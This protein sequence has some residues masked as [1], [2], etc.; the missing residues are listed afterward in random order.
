M[1]QVKYAVIILNYNTI[2]DAINAARSVIDN[3][4][5]DEYVVCIADNDS[6]KTE[7]REKLK[8]VFLP[9][10]VTCQ[11][12]ENGGYAKGNNQAIEFLL[13]TYAPQYT[14]IMNPDVLLL[15]NGTIEG[16]IAGFENEDAVGGQPLVW[17]CYYGDDPTVQQNIRKVPDYK[18][19]RN[20]ML[21]PL[22]LFYKR[23]Y[24]EY[25]YADQMPYKDHIRYYVPSGAFFILRTDVFKEIGFFDDHT[26][27]YYEEHILGYKLQR[28]GL[29]LLLMP[30]FKV[31]HEH[32]K[33][34]GA[35]RFSYNQK[36]SNIGMESA[37]YYA[38]KYVGITERQKRHLIG[39]HCVNSFMMRI[40]FMLKR[41]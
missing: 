26:F 39:L 24:R 29:E 38:E 14:V 5:S 13:Q 25:T 9:H 20:L 36:A 41:R 34:T 1:I 11:L 7:D 10:V 16:L 35:N 12:K 17:N 40:L 23:R 30:E 31:R 6:S 19:L 28:K 15:E 22:R 37:L 32:G 33:S 18:D 27:L 3:A 21:K 4:V 2:D 8:S